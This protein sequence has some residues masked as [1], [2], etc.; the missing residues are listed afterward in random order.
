MGGSCLA[1]EVLRRA[2]GGDRFHVLDTTHPKA[3]RRLA[4]SLDLERTLFVVSSK[5]GGTL[6]TRSHFDFFWE[7]SKRG[8]RFVAITD[9]ALRSRSSA[10]ERGLARLR[11]RADDRRPLLGAVD[12]RAAARP[13]RQVT[14]AA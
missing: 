14:A 9:P 3:I 12:V 5:S 4:D 2:F 7:R 8:D 6:E 13:G 1:P 11:R 10:R